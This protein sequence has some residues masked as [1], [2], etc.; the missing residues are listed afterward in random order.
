MIQ[1]DGKTLVND[2]R[3]PDPLLA[4]PDKE[5]ILIRVIPE[6][7]RNLGT[8]TID[9][10]LPQAMPAEWMPRPI[11]ARCAC[12]TS[13]KRLTD[14]SFYIVVSGVVTGARLSLRAEFPAGTFQLSVGEKTVV[15]LERWGPWLLGLAL[16]V[17]VVSLGFLVWLIRE[18]RDVRKFRLTPRLIAQP[19]DQ[20]TPALISMIP[21][22]KITAATLASM[23]L[24]LSQRGF[25][26]MMQKEKNFLLAEDRRLD[27]TGPGFA[28]GSLPGEIIPEEEVTKAANEG[29]TLAEKFLL[30]KLFTQD[31]P[32][33]SQEDLKVR[34][35]RRLTSWKVGKVY[36]ELYKQATADG[37][38]IKNPHEIHLRYRALGVGIFFL[39][40]AGIAMSL[41]LP[42]NPLALV[43]TWVAVLIT[44]RVITKMVPY[45]PLL[46]VLGQAEWA[47]WAG[48]RAYLTDGKPLPKTRPT[49]LFFTYLPYAAAFDA[50]IPWA[51]R[52]A[53]RPVEAPA[54][55][56]TGPKKKSVRLMADELEHLTAF[57]TELLAALHEHTVR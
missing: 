3:I 36:A 46:T 39:G 16:A 20:V 51:Q 17:L 54:W 44:G 12:E 13:I 42:G 56:L 25:V 37:Y 14:Q 53:D 34:F 45:L 8:V 7:P 30:A 9:L 27:L 41:V 15:G 43:A 50:V 18:L 47:R 52:F 40:L 31:H 29:V 24:S 22:G 28:L 11:P 19:P 35:G 48:F 10:R 4:T 32:V 2:D 57:V 6:A 26:T 49:T 38:F 33:V 21:S 5:V 23:L 1:A 55:Y